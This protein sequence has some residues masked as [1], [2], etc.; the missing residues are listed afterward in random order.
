MSAGAR[1]LIS[2]SPVGLRRA[3][4]V[5]VIAATLLFVNAIFAQPS[6]ARTNGG[7]TVQ[8]VAGAA[9]A[10]APSWSSSAQGWYFRCSYAGWAHVRVNFTC[11]LVNGFTNTTL[12][13]RSGSFSDG[14]HLTSQ[15]FYKKS[16]SAYLCTVAS[17]SYADG[18]DS[19][20]E[21]RC[22]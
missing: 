11:K 21:R 2:P 8:Y 4:A 9:T 22:N 20:S 19:D 18:S 3:A 14:S 12:F 1:P 6:A 10:V 17:A 13:S 5:G 16:S 7:V 15:F